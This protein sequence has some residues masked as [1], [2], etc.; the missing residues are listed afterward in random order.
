MAVVVGSGRCQEPCRGAQGGSQ[1]SVPS[2]LFIPEVKPELARR[3][4]PV[5]GYFSRVFF[6]IFIFYNRTIS[7]NSVH[8]LLFIKL[9]PPE[10]PT[11]A[12]LPLSPPWSCEGKD[13]GG[14]GESGVRVRAGRAGAFP[15]RGRARRCE[16]PRRERLR[17]V[18][19]EGPGP[20]VGGAR[21]APGGRRRR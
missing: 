9:K 15:R 3:P 12:C 1:P 13:G 11:A 20:G 19:A 14:G 6:F 17:S 18:G 2:R 21:P 5:A 7:V 4:N 8:L 16:G 10:A